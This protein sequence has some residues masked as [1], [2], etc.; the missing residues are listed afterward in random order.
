MAANSFYKTLQFKLDIQ[1]KHADKKVPILDFA[2]WS[3]REPDCTRENQ[4]REAVH[5][6]FYEK[7]VVS[8]KVIE[9]KSAMAI[10]VKITTLS[11]EIIR[12]L[13]NTSRSATAEERANIITTF[14]MK[15]MLSGY[16]ESLTLTEQNWKLVS[17]GII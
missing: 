13:K 3:Q 11:Q 15:M 17:Q 8:P 6:T 7:E 5:H 10:R 1:E 9:Y 16:P 4:T 2:V 12:S 14:M